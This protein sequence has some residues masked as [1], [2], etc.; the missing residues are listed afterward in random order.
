MAEFAVQEATVLIIDDEVA[1]TR[2]LEMVLQSRGCNRLISVNDSRTALAQ[3]RRVQPDIVL[4]DLAMPNVDGFQLLEQFRNEPGQA[5]VPILILTADASSESKHRSLIEG[6]SDFLTKPFD[7]KEVYLRVSNLAFA[8][9]NTNLLKRLVTAR[10]SEL[11][12]AQLETVRRLALAAEFRDDATGLHT[13]RV[14]DL[15][16]GIAKNLAW[17]HEDVDLLRIAA[18]LHDVG[19]IGIPDSILLK[20]GRLTADEFAVMKTHTIIGSKI[21]SGSESS[22]LNLAD[23]IALYHHERWDGAGYAQIPSIQVPVAARIVMV[24]DVFDALTHERPYKQAW[25]FEDALKEIRS[26]SGIGFDPEV[27]AAFEKL[28]LSRHGTGMT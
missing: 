18:P 20:P 17:S 11:E 13:M 1:N 8:R 6:A 7:A 16:A 3:F 28:V 10:T 21:L 15:S 25:S 5:D 19:K 26:Q 27:V 12:H 24:A 4:L 23:R 9:F 14:G 22:V 2:L